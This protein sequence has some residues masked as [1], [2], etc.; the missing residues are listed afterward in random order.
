MRRLYVNFSAVPQPAATNESIINVA[1]IFTKPGKIFDILSALKLGFECDLNEL[2]AKLSVTVTRL[3][4]LSILKGT[5]CF[6][7]AL[8]GLLRDPGL[9]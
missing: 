4:A 2:A 5:Y 6:E 8:V 7:T 9:T 1:S 3:S